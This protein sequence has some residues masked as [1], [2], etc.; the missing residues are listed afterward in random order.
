MKMR[1]LV[2][3]TNAINLGEQWK[4][5]HPGCPNGRCGLLSGPGSAGWKLIVS[6]EGRGLTEK[7]CQNFKEDQIQKAVQ[8]K[9]FNIS[10]K[11]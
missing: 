5:E 2:A 3:A 7:K 8:Y 10:Y 4:S 6:H 9:N 11:K 1:T